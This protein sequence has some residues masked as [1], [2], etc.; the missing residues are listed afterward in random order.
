MARHISG[1]AVRPLKIPPAES[2]QLSTRPVL[3]LQPPK[4]LDYQ[5]PINRIDASHVLQVSNF[6]LDRGVMR[7]R[8]GTVVVG[9]AATE[10]VM[11]VINFVI[12]S[13][14]GFVLRVTT[15]RMQILSGGVWSAIGGAP[16]TGSTQDH[17]TFTV[18]NDSLLLS[19]GIDG[20][21]E[22]NPTAG[23]FQKLVGAPS[24]KHLTTFA[25]R[26]IASG[27]DGI[28]TRIRWSVKNNS[29]DWSGIGSGFEDLLS[30]P[31]GQ[32]DQQVGVWPLSE[33]LA[34]VVRSNSVWQMTET[35]NVDIPFR[36]SRIYDNLGTRSP[37]SVDAVPGGVVFFG[38]DDIYLIDDR[39]IKAIGTLVKNRLQSEALDFADVHGVYSPKTKEYLLTVGQSTVYRYSFQDE[40]WTKSDYP[41]TI[42]A[43]EESIYHKGSLTIDEL[44]GTINSLIGITD[45]L[46]GTPV[47]GVVY[48]A[49]ADALGMIYGQS[50]SATND[51]AGPAG[52]SLTTGVITAEDVL[53]FV[54]VNE[55][56]LEYES[57]SNQT[58]TMEW[59]SNGGIDWNTYDVQVIADTVSGPELVSFRRTLT[60]KNILLRL[61]SPTLGRLSIVGLFP[62]IF[63]AGKVHP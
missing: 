58:L 12:G 59:S 15:K 42:R 62:H 61:S 11:A 33:G 28:P 13:G 57:E 8:Y 46:T 41:F 1:R 53:K 21:W 6:W 17:F 43:I 39:S 54:T 60:A 24:A 27:A 2:F 30:T 35:G 49:T 3:Y 48:F 4:G 29:H 50:I 19:N 14:V 18:F 38:T 22:Y 44:Q 40:G 51:T 20:I 52:I 63:Q 5:S 10:P 55:V 32:V 9:Q 25:G 23:S 45:N 16:F 47:A 37:R 7:S 36:F 34:L 26:V 31:G 56:Q